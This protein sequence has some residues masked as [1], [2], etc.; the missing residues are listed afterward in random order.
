[1]AW[2]SFR[3]QATRRRFVF[4]GLLALGTLIP[5]TGCKFP[6]DAKTESFRATRKD[7]W[8]FGKEHTS[9]LLHQV[10][11]NP[12]ARQQ[13]SSAADPFLASL[14]GIGACWYPLERETKLIE[15]IIKGNRIS[16]LYDLAPTPITELAVPYSE[17]ILAIEKVPELRS[18]NDSFK[19]SLVRLA[20][21]MGPDMA[22]DYLL[23]TKV[24][25]A[26][27][28]TL[29]AGL[30]IAGAPTGGLTWAAAAASA[31]LILGMS[32][33]TIGCAIASNTTG[34]FD[35]LKAP[36]N[37]VLNPLKDAAANTAGEVLNDTDGRRKAIAER[38]FPM[39]SEGERSATVEGSYQDIPTIGWD[40][41]QRLQRLI[42]E[43]GDSRKPK[44]PSG[45]SKVTAAS[46][47][48]RSIPVLKATGEFFSPD[49]EQLPQSMVNTLRERGYSEGEIN[50]FVQQRAPR[51]PE[52]Q[53]K[54]SPQM[55]GTQSPY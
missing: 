7:W 9:L 28:V 14:N 23:C 40:E 24:M 1:M 4:S 10:V 41:M 30:A 39:D 8:I 15:P 5:V 44:Y 49:L 46:Q 29:G 20:V 47:R 31:P 42:G 54:P 18:I 33:G 37:T 27:G 32:T 50:Q 36:V 12:N 22:I 43:L 25:A 26:L 34:A 16:E 52:T 21:D 13:Q 55:K 51:A 45:S 35:A 38:L 3:L 19:K 2:H 17:L 11:A 6:T 48:C 53:M